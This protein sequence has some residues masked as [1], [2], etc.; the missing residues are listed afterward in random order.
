MSYNHLIT[1]LIE[2]FDGYTGFDFN[3]QTLFF[4]H[5]SIR[6]QKDIGIFYEKFYN[7]AISR[8]IEKETDIFK[9]LKEN[10]DWN[11]SDDL[12]I[13]QLQE[14]IEN[15]KITKNKLMLPSQKDAHQNLINEESIKLNNLLTKKQ[16]LTGISAEQYANK[17]ANEEFIRLMI[18]SDSSLS[19]IHFS[20]E[21]FG[22][23]DIDE[24]NFLNKKYISISEKFTDEKVQKI[25]LQ[26]FFSMYLSCCENPHVF[27]GKFIHQLSAYQMKLLLY[28]KI[29]YNIFQYNDDIPE[30]LRK[31][32]KSIFDFVESKKTREKFQN[33]NKDSD[34]TM[35]FGATK[36]DLDILDPG[37]R[38]VSLSEALEK[39]GGTL[40]MEQMM[41]LM[42]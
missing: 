8:G 26:D 20:N 10:N 33:Q 37:A 31:D 42:G 12:K 1:D 28:G 4:R 19:K 41:D 3:G 38:K 35:V 18:Y 14:Y 9:R 17:M 13:A 21:E 7:I 6:D 11:D 24:L 32:P 30:S 23:L 16:E 39:A 5:F 2:I 36:T 25:V 27:F 34:G 40:N 15:L 29:F 22:Y